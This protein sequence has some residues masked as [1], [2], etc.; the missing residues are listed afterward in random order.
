MHTTFAPTRDPA[1][2]SLPEALQGVALVIHGLN[3]KPERLQ[4]LADELRGCG[5]AVVLC[6]LRGHGEN[7]TPLA[8]Y[9][10]EIARLTAFRQVSY[11]GWRAEVAAAYQTAVTYASATDV[12]IFLVAFSLGALLGCE[13][14][15]TS[16]GVNFAR[17]VLLAPA[18]A[19]HPYCHLPALFARWPQL[20][21]RSLAPSF[22]RANPVTPIAAYG[23]L[24]AML[25]QLHCQPGTALNLP[26]LVFIDP[27]DEVVS[28]QGIRRFIHDKGL[29][30]WQL[31]LICK[32]PVHTGRT[33][34]HLI[35]D[36]AS[37]GPAVWQ[38]MIAQITSHLVGQ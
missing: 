2:A 31:H 33:V 25:H 23:V 29:T 10:A 28:V 27:A 36:P 3:V 26:S 17:M 20:A 34:H 24:Y 16:P 1:Y 11:A 4:P 9:S 30:R 22:Y 5:I 38:R 13:L 21:I 12:P 18:L 6:S 8:G 15:V 14:L 35:L 7:Y 32:A 37:V 19:I